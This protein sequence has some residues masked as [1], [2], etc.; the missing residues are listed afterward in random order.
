M[1]HFSSICWIIPHAH[2][3]PQIEVTIFSNTR[4]A[5][6]LSLITRNLLNF[7]AGCA[8][9]PPGC[10]VSQPELWRTMSE[11]SVVSVH[12]YHSCPS[13]S[14]CPA[15]VSPQSAG[16][17]LCSIEFGLSVPT[18][19]FLKQHALLFSFAHSSF[20]NSLE[21]L[22]ISACFLDLPTCFNFLA[23]V[24]LHIDRTLAK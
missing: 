9:G 8:S 12:F 21:A 16:A 7:H 5:L 19:L 6:M 24:F 23:I 11:A 2:V 10:Q 14:C 3:V 20:R 1:F 13:R 4:A 17:C 22:K 15:Y 18:W